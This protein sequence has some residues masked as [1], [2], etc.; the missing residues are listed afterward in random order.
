MDYIALPGVDM[1]L[2]VTPVKYGAV[3]IP[4]EAQCSVESKLHQR[5]PL[6]R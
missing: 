5:R 2:T 1:G 3:E 4:P 6:R